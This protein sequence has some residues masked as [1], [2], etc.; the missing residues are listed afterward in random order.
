[1]WAARETDPT[2]VVTRFSEA[3]R[4]EP[5]SSMVL[6]SRTR[7]GRSSAA[8]PDVEIRPKSDTRPEPE[9][10]NPTEIQV[11]MSAICEG[12]SGA[13][14]PDIPEIASEYVAADRPETFAAFH[15][16]LEIN[17]NFTISPNL[18]FLTVEC[19]SAV[20]LVLLIYFC[21]LVKL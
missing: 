7:G 5:T 11:S 21:S 18:L 13:T 4:V 6:R 15:T 2:P 1:M 12:G 14:R 8:I 3:S 10:N 20:T 9:I 17:S 19:T 16:S